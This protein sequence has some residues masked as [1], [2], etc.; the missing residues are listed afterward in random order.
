MRSFVQRSLAVHAA[1]GLALVAVTL[2]AQQT[3]YPPLVALPDGPVTL[4]TSRR[5][6]T[7]AKIPGPRVR[8]LVTKGLTRPYA[9]AFL[10]DGAVL[11]TERPG[12][13]RIVRNG[14]L[15]PQPIGGLPPV[16]DRQFKGLNDIALHPRFAENRW[17][18]FTYYKP[19]PEAR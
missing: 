12:R 13:L 7:G 17:V 6:P 5:A 3:V 1:L 16:L 18:Y 15:D 2:S 14:V 9:L 8:V 4:D 10:P 11:V 19:R